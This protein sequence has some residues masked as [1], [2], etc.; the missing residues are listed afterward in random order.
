M[1][2]CLPP[3]HP[4]PIAD[5]SLA[6]SPFPLAPLAYI[7]VYAS[8]TSSCIQQ[9]WETIRR[10]TT[11]SFSTR[12]RS[13]LSGSSARGRREARPSRP[14]QT[15][16]RLTT[17]TSACENMFLGCFVFAL[18]CCTRLQAAA[19]VYCSCFAL[20]VGCVC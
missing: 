10:C 16:S 4:P 12:T 8:N 5:C 3:V 11:H 19:V 14:S 20:F 17:A 9:A 13:C 1:I 6:P 18:C 7:F 15:S 2:L